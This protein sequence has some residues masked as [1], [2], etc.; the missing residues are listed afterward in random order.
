MARRRMALSEK[1]HSNATRLYGKREAFVAK[2]KAMMELAGAEIKADLAADKEY[3]KEFLSTLKEGASRAVMDR[4]C[5]GV[6]ARLYELAGEERKLTVELIHRLGAKSE[7]ELR[8]YVEAAKSVE[9]ASLH[10]SAERCVA[11]LEMYFQQN[12][13]MRGPAVKRLGGYVAV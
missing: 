3:Q 6:M 5:I 11:F 1:R 12:P 9:G 2:A 8:G 4:T 10:D 7:D 13:N